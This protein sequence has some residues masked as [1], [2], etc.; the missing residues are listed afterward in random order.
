MKKTLFLAAGVAAALL[1][2]AHPDA[3]AQVRG[4]RMMGRMPAM[5][6]PDAIPQD[7]EPLMANRLPGIQSIVRTLE[8]AGCPL[9]DEQIKSIR[10]TVRTQGLWVGITDILTP[11]QENALEVARQER[12]S[13]LEERREE[14][15]NTLIDREINRLTHILE[16]ADCP[17]TDDQ[18]DQLKSV[19]P[20]TRI[21]ESL[22][23]ILTD[24]QQAALLD[25]RRQPLVRPFE[26]DQN[27]PPPDFRRRRTLRPGSLD[28]IEGLAP[29]PA[30]NTGTDGAAKDTGIAGQPIAFTGINQNFPNPFNP[31]TTIEYSLAEPGNVRL[32]IFNGNGQRIETLVDG[33][34]GA[35][36]HS[37]VWDA[38]S[39]A[40]GVYFCR[41][42]AGT[43]QD[44]RK[45]LYVK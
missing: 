22:V 25:A 34:Q 14:M 40:N 7:R 20:G 15:K 32:E 30:P 19:D 5:P 9:T 13:A 45:M 29:S 43:V 39:Q 33:W 2:I 44:T 27:A 26:R 8:E 28:D 42:T 23:D 31:A 24:E 6:S 17:L 35:G 4:P 11:E 37:M 16:E 38:S 21:G 1:F 12:A 36:T 18:I 41:I 10:E 3:F